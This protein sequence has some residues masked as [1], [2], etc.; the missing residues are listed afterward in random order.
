VANA[1]GQTHGGCSGLAQHGTGAA[2]R[3]DGNEGNPKQAANAT[4]SGPPPPPC[5][6]YAALADSDAKEFSLIVVNTGSAP[7]TLSVGLAGEFDSLCGV[8]LQV[9]CN[10][11][12]SLVS[13]T[14]LHSHDHLHSPYSD[15]DVSFFLLVSQL[16]SYF[17]ASFCLM[18]RSSLS[19]RPRSTTRSDG[20]QSRRPTLSDCPTWLFRARVVVVVVLVLV[21]VVVLLGIRVG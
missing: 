1:S 15:S 13:C 17:S 8:G 21:L 14:L 3:A 20:N 12:M 19:P 6:T 4:A 7:G 16:F 5:L 18:C 10:Q 9:R 2:A 11:R